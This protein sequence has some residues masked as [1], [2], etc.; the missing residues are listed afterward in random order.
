MSEFEHRFRVRQPFSI[1]TP[2]N[3]KRIHEGA[4]RIME[5][6]GIRVL[7]AKARAELG[8]AGALVDERSK[9]VKFPAEVVLSQI[10]SVPSKMVL[11]GRTKDCDLPVD[12]SHHY[13]TT[14]G[15]G[16]S[17]WEEGSKTRRGSTLAGIT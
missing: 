10:R 3:K 15:C 6:T 1:L 9:V 8:E 5:S 17:V 13:Y 7:S 4:L 16:V 14:D 2:Q 12:G 11:A